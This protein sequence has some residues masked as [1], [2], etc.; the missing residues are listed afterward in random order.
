MGDNLVVAGDLSSSE[1]QD[2]NKSQEILTSEE[3]PIKNGGTNR[4][5]QSPSTSPEGVTRLEGNF[6]YTPSELKYIDLK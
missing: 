6:R 2:S 3:V 4:Q 5:S 1:S